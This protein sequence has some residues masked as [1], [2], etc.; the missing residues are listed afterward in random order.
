MCVIISLHACVVIALFTVVYVCCHFFMFARIMYVCS[1]P[2]KNGI[3]DWLIKNQKSNQKKK[4]ILHTTTVGRL[5]LI[6]ELIV[7]VYEYCD[8]DAHV[9]YQRKIIM[10]YTIQ[11]QLLKLFRLLFFYNGKYQP[12]IKFT[13]IHVL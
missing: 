13:S 1:L 12:L 6:I 2:G 10:L 3:A 5:L 8:V 11:R 4:I 7:V 9:Q